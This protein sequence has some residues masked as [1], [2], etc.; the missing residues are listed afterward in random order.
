[1][2]VYGETWCPAIELDETNTDLILKAEVPGV[3][4]KDL[5]IHAE[6]ESLSIVGVHPRHKQKTEKELMPSQLHYGQLECNIPLPVEIQVEGVRAELISGIL[7]ITMPKVK[8]P[9]HKTNRASAPSS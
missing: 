5:N 3:A 1:M 4:I 2:T 7:T 8:I 6:S 9:S